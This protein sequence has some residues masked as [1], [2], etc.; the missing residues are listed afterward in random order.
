MSGHFRKGSKVKWKWG[1][2]EAE[3]VIAERFTRKVTRTIKG[4]KI[5]RN[6]TEAEPAYLVEQEDGGRALKSASELSAA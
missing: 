1:A 4:E 6:A 2:H 5:V 3:G